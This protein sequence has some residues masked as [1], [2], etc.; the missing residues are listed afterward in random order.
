[1]VYSTEN[2]S[3]TD[4]EKAAIG[5]GNGESLTG[6]DARAGVQIRPNFSRSV[7]RRLR[8]GRTTRNVQGGNFDQRQFAR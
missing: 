7:H 6:D 1:M 5:A 4:D 3:F 8:L 2:A